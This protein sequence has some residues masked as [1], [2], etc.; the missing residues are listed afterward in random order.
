MDLPL[1]SH[2]C[3]ESLMRGSCNHFAVTAVQKQ[4]VVDGLAGL[5]ECVCVYVCIYIYVFMCIYI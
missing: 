3:S 4:F 1:W 5:S 2:K